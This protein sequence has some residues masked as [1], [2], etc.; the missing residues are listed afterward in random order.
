MRICGIYTYIAVAVSSIA[1]HAVVSG[2]PLV[3]PTSALLL[4]WLL[5]PRVGSQ[6]PAAVDVFSSG[7]EN[8]KTKKSGSGQRHCCTAVVCIILLFVYIKMSLPPLQL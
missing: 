5:N 4:W 1:V 7:K 3:G 8:K 2:A 6:Q